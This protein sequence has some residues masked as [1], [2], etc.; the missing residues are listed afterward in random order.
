VLVCP[1]KSLKN[2]HEWVKYYIFWGW[3]LIGVFSKI[4][5]KAGVAGYPMM[6]VKPV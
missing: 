4:L 5:A 2:C 3:A 1:L 6:G